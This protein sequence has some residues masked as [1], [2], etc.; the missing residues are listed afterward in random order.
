MTGLW[1]DW[2][3]VQPAQFGQQ[4]LPIAYSLLFYCTVSATHT[5]P[6]QFASDEVA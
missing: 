6:A 1:E 2:L 3:L 5:A 4:L